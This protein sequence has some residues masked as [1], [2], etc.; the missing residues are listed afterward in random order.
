VWWHVDQR[1][2]SVVSVRVTCEAGNGAIVQQVLRSRTALQWRRRLPLDC[3]VSRGFTLRNP[4][5]RPGLEGKAE[6]RA[7]SGT[8]GRRSDSVGVG[9]LATETAWN[10]LKGREIVDFFFPQKRR[11]SG[12]KG[13]KYLQLGPGRAARNSQVQVPWAYKGCA[14]AKL[15]KP[16]DVS[17][18][19]RRKLLEW[20]YAD[21][22]MEGMGYGYGLEDFGTWK[23]DGE[24][25]QVVMWL[26]G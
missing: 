24:G 1:A 12:I 18:F 8:V 10:S 2:G 9:L 14:G 15:P 16:Y 3:L 20:A 13:T 4:R 22:W 25:L 17:A 21:R 7:N 26:C 6:A 23:G 19:Q 5:W 11:R